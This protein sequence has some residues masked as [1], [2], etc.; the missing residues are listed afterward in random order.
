MLDNTI[1][2][3][4]T[5]DK[6]MLRDRIVK[7]TTK[8]FNEG[9]VDE[10]ATLSEEYGWENEAMTGNIYPILR[11]YLDRQLS[12]EDAKQAS[13]VKDWHLAK[14]Q[15]TWFRRNTAIHWLDLKEAEHF[16]D[17]Q[18]FDYEQKYATV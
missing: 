8:M 13:I 2:V 11:Q 9:V 16:I 18:L 4:L 7:R 3:G 17:A 6:A 12:L 14:R 1:V 15:M 10:A 5:T